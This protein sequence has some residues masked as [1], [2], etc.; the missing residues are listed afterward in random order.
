MDLLRGLV[1]DAGGEWALSGAGFVLVV[2]LMIAIRLLGARRGRT[3]GLRLVVAFLLL[4]VA[5]FSV[6]QVL[7]EGWKT[8]RAMLGTGAVLFLG[9]ALGRAAFLLVFDVLLAPEREARQAP[10]LPRIVRDIVQGLIYLMVALAALRAAGVE[11]GQLLTTS[12]LLTVVAGLALQETL[13]NLLAGLSLQLERP[14]DVGDW[15]E[16]H[17]QPAHFGRVREINWRSTRLHT[18]DNTDV[19]VPNGVIA[20]TPVTNYDR[21]HRAARRSVYFAAPYGAPPERV[22]AVVLDAIADAEGVL[23]N[24]PPSV[25]TFKFDESGITYWV[26]FF[27]DDMSRRDVYDSNV[28]DRIWY[29]LARAELAFPYPTRTVHLHE[30]SEESGKRREAAARQ[31]RQA[32]LAVIDF[33][34]ELPEPAIALLAERARSLAFARGETVIKQGDPGD[35][36]FVVHEGELSVRVSE[37]ERDVEV[38]RLSEGGFFGEMSLLTGEPRRATVVALRACELY[39]LGHDAFHAVLEAHPEFARVVSQH[40]AER[41]S[42]L[43]RDRASVISEEVKVEDADLLQRIRS[44]FKLTR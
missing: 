6:R 3:L 32:D 38:A 44:F 5:V 34:A 23:A 42:S 2:V 30:V 37:A 7:P 16:V 24:P 17:G 1:G 13:G 11:P 33:L 27:I 41:T 19:I 9:L 15:I 4:H 12:A 36:M 21:P 25:V 40:V 14:F 43:A 28:R 8:F 22:R 26:R 35:T 18:L 39:E 20:K 10:P 31:V 29:A